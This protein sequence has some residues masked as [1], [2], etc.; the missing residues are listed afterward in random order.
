MTEDLCPPKVP[1]FFSLPAYTNDSR[2]VQRREG[3]KKV[4]AL[5]AEGKNSQAYDVAKT[6]VEVTP[7]MVQE[8]IQ[9]LRTHNIEFIVS[10]YESD[11]Q[12]THLQRIGHVDAI[13]TE[14]SDLLAFGCDSVLY[15]VTKESAT[16]INSSDI[17]KM[18]GFRNCIMATYCQGT[19]KSLGT[20][21]SSLD[22]ITLLLCKE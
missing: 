16:L 20:C 4:A 2:R 21:A 1:H 10:P 9:E 22:A 13:L 8:V 5:V 12:L 3:K 15:K 7:R 11:A 19:K 14:D 18:K 17:R 6:A